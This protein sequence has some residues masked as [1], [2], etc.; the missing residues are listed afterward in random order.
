LFPLVCF[1]VFSSFYYFFHVFSSPRFSLYLFLLFLSCSVFPTLS[2]LVSFV[3]YWYF[4]IFWYW[5][6]YRYI[7]QLQ[8]GWHPVAVHIY[9]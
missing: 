9:T 1:F 7:C 5:Y 4:L 3:I 8:L 6:W 2:L